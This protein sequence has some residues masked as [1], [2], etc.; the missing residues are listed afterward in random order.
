MNTFN[1][2]CLHL[3]NELDGQLDTIFFNS[4]IVILDGFHV[5]PDLLRYVV[6]VK[7]N[8]TTKTVIVLDREY[9]RK[10]RAGD[11]NSPTSLDKIEKD[12]HIKEE[13]S[14]N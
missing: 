6:I 7:R 2:S 12:I 9:T 11:A 3:L 14:Y 5:F 10:D 1:A 8:N 4:S 13:L